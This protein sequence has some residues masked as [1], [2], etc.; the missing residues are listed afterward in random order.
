MMDTVGHLQSRFRCWLFAG[1]CI[2]VAAL[3]RDPFLPI[4]YRIEV[5]EPIAPEVK[6]DLPT[7]PHTETVKEVQASEWDEARKLLQVDGFA[8]AVSEGRK[9]QQRIVMINRLTYRS[10]DRLSL[11]NQ[12]VVFS[13]RVQ[14]PEERRLELVPGMAIRL[15]QEKRKMPR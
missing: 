11:T 15:E 10:G 13:W 1:T 14:L 8:S 3:A 5:P 12:G 9:E 4:G 2:T 7:V 6:T